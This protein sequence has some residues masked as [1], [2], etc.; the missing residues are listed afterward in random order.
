MGTAAIYRV[1]GAIGVVVGA[2]ACTVLS[3]P[4]PLDVEDGLPNFPGVKGCQAGQP[5]CGCSAEGVSMACGE[6]TQKSGDYLTCSEGHSICQGGIWQK[7]DG[8]RD[9][10]GGARFVKSEADLIRVPLTV[11]DSAICDC[12][13]KESQCSACNRDECTEYVTELT[14]ASAPARLPDGFDLGPG[15]GLTLEPINAGVDASTRRHYERKT[16]VEDFVADCEVG[17]EPRWRKF[18]FVADIP[19]SDA[20]AASVSIAVQSGG[21]LSSLQSSRALLLGESTTSTPVY[22]GERTWDSF[23]IDTSSPEAN[24]QSGILLRAFVALAPT[25][26]IDENTGFESPTVLKWEV[27]SE[28]LRSN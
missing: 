24:L 25:P 22:G 17:F 7:C 13:S 15:G 6:V 16:F 27:E 19:R 5:G 11:D 14:D 28:C 12:A 26:D 8:A 2:Y 10:T 18:A 1:I 3:Q 23:L 4:T 9:L 20:G 21:D